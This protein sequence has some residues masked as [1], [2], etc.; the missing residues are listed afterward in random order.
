MLYLIFS[1]HKF[2]SFT[3]KICID[4]NLKLYYDITECFPAINSAL[5]NIQHYEQRE[6]IIITMKRPCPDP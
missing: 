2:V 6:T 1:F 4:N 5:S 3:V